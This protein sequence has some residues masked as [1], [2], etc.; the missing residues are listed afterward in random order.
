MVTSFWQ[1]P[2]SRGELDRLQKLAE[3]GHRGMVRPATRRSGFSR[4]VAARLVK[5]R[6]SGLAAIM[7]VI[8][9]RGRRA[10]ADAS[11]KLPTRARP[12]AI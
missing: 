6:P 9:D 8:T 3:A 4:L 7:Y 5:A 11:K 2:L 1:K 10:L 12:G